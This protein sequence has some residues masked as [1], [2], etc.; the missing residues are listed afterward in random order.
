MKAQMAA[1]LD[2]ELRLAVLQLLAGSPGD[3]TNVHV[4]ERALHKSGFQVSAD[5]LRTHLAWLSDQGY[6][7][8]ATASDAP[9]V[10]ITVRGLDVARG[11]AEA[12]GVAPPRPRI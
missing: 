8:P 6:V 11:L 12:P 1:A 4:V 3:G 10:S 2:E 5:R 7:A 9:V